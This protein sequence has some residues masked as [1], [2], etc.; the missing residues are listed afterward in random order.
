MHV[1]TRAIYKMLKSRTAGMAKASFSLGTR[2]FSSRSAFSSVLETSF[3]LENLGKA[4]ILLGSLGQSFLVL[5]NAWDLPWCRVLLRRLN[6]DSS[7][8]G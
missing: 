2:G 7:Q 5:G 8:S 3:V 6:F 4:S 1:A